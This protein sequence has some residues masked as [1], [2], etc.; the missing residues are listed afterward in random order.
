MIKTIL[1]ILML[2]LIGATYGAFYS[3][4]ITAVLACLQCFG[5]INTEMSYMV[6]FQLLGTWV[7]LLVITIGTGTYI[8]GETE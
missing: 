4:G 8:I 2:P 3:V 7:L 5:I 6:P 1:N